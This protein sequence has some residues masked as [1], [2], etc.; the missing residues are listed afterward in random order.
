MR[1][2]LLPLLLTRGPG[3]LPAQSPSQAASTAPS[4]AR[5]GAA[6]PGTLL[7][8]PSWLWGW[9]PKAGS[10]MYLVPASLQQIGWEGTAACPLLGWGQASPVVTPVPAQGVTFR[11]T[12]AVCC[13]ECIPAPALYHACPPLL[14]SKFPSGSKGGR[15][16]QVEKRLRQRY[17]C[18]QR[19]SG[20]AVCGG[21]QPASFQ[22]LPMPRQS[23]AELCYLRRRF[24]PH[25]SFF[26]MV[27]WQAR[28]WWS[29][30]PAPLCSPLS[31]NTTRAFQ[32]FCISEF[33]LIDIVI[34]Q[35]RG[36]PQW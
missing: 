16:C 3:S 26:S 32:F 7:Q 17:G 18:E 15:V 6:A 30:S 1:G 25:L 31:C 4:D 35:S 21:E 19:A 10:Q 14:S 22:P 24:R 13:R 8:E 11:Q 33:F 12:T 27:C 36:C 2:G 29:T 9:Q 5:A 20:R 23:A 34:N 28:S